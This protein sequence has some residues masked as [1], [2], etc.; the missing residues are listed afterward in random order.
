MPHARV[1]IKLVRANGF[2]ANLR[3][4]REDNTDIVIYDYTINDSMFSGY[5]QT[6]DGT[7]AAFSLYHT[8]SLN[9]NSYRY[10]FDSYAKTRSNTTIAAPKR[11]FVK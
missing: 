8:S 6:N 1:T 7:R 4:F 11:M 5:I 2:A 3:H 10:G 9:W